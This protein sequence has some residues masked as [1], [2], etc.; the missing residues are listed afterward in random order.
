MKYTMNVDQ[1]GAVRFY[2]AF[3][4]EITDPKKIRQIKSSAAYRTAKGQIDQARKAQKEN[5]SIN[6]SI[7]RQQQKARAAEE[8]A[9]QKRVFVQQGKAEVEHFNATIDD[10][11]KIYTLSSDIRS[12]K[13][14][15]QTIDDIRTE[16]ESLEAQPQYT[17]KEFSKPQPS[18]AEARR[19]LQS[20]AES[21]ITSPFFRRSKQEKYIEEGLMKKLNYLNEK[22][23]EEK[24]EFVEEES[25]HEL[26]YNSAIQSRL[27][28]LDETAFVQALTGN[29][30]YIIETI[31]SNLNEIELPA[32]PAYSFNYDQINKTVCIDLDLPT[33]DTMPE[34]RAYQKKSGEINYKPIAKTERQEL[35]AGYVIG[36]AVLYS[37]YIFDVS[38]VITQRLCSRFS[39]SERTATCK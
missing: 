7:A 16:R 39:V 25:K 19:L 34:Q 38:P 20:E 2:T 14:I 3:G 31:K 26:E 18:E 35:Y 9:A 15:Q 21:F 28:E 6:A 4:R 13:A 32:N 1:Y 5:A 24:R 23:E 11:A 22:W 8:K 10:L 33:I 17:K 29:D 37:S 36:L 27:A 12:A 30:T